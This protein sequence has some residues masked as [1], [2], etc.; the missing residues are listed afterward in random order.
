MNNNQFEFFKT[1]K[2]GSST[3]YFVIDY[4]SF[5]GRFETIEFPLDIRVEMF[6]SEIK[7]FAS[8]EDM[9]KA[10]KYN[11]QKLEVEDNDIVIY[12]KYEVITGTPVWVDV[13]SDTSRITRQPVSLEVNNP[14]I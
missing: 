8:E 14:N 6:P 10:D 3:V 4:Y 13:W 5:E 12:K 11:S 2:N 9:K 7:L 1:S